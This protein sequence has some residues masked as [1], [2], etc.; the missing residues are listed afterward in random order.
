MRRARLDTRVITTLLGTELRMLLRDR[1]T[2]LFSI[3][4][5]LLVM[6][7]MMFGSHFMQQRRERSLQTLVFTYAV[8]GSE[9]A[10][11][12]ARLDTTLA[13]LTAEPQHKPE[14]ITLK[15]LPTTNPLKEL[16]DGT[17]HVVVE[18]T[19][20]EEAE[21]A[22]Q[23]QARSA[24]HRAHDV[25]ASEARDLAERPQPG[26]PALTLVYRA[27]RDTSVKAM[28]GLRKALQETR[29]LERAAAL[30]A[31]GFPIPA[32]DVATVTAKDLASAGQVAGLTLGR[33]LTLLLLMFILSGGAVVA[34]DTLAGEK[35]RGTLETLLATAAGRLE[36]VTAKLL[37]IL[38]VSLV[39][40]LIQVA[41]FLLYVAFK[42]VPTTQN[43]A[44]AVPPQVAL[45]LLAL[46]IPVAALASAALLLTS[47]Y[48]KTYKEAQLYFFPLLL[49]GMVPALA[50]FL[51]GLALRSPIVLVPVA[52]IAMAVKE[53]LTGTY[54]WP[55]IVVAL[56]VTSGTA[57]WVTFV[58]AR[59]L[60]TERLISP[61]HVDAAQA[62]GGPALF[63]RH[64]LRWFALMWAAVLIVSVNQ[65][66][67]TDIRVQ[68][69]VNLVLIFFGATMLMLK[70][71]RLEPG[72]AL[73]LRPVRPVV[74]LAVLLGA[75]TAL[76]TGV[77]VF[78]LANLVLPVPPEALRGFQ[79][80]LLPDAVP[81][82]QLLALL[83]IMPGVF[84][85][86]AFRGVLLHGL[87][88][89]LRPLP[90]ALVVGGIFGLF[91]FS[92]FRI[93]PVSF[94]GI[95]LA[96]VT[97]LTGSIFPAMLWHAVNNLMG[98]ALAHYGIELGELPVGVHLAAATILVGAFW[99]L[100]RTRTPYPGLRQ[101]H[102]PRPTGGP[103][104]QAL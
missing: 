4:L 84:E 59:A 31:H 20:A 89:R 65:K 42:L 61:T 2:I 14:S 70:K 97:L 7:V 54:D 81:F 69:I 64:V 30:Q 32:A 3:V 49:V 1:R 93:V 29:R 104:T 58:T 5:P 17:L 62:L 76:L 73:A 23:E 83:S 96:G 27:D 90:L 12:K 34:T 75:P 101:W 79:Q 92:L 91:H 102:R 15:E 40:T 86:L 45:L 77:G 63:P 99:I 82:W 68:L 35:E 6:P 94:L 85:E 57:A 16:Q 26:V 38:A 33:L 28:A 19:T 72:E 56:V 71:Y 88:R 51:P 18:A 74:W 78:R 41:N 67:G 13:R 9:A 95:M 43:F 46:F 39:I 24:H 100:W 8:T 50:P 10:A 44:A 55:M 80:E 66:E 36:I 47:G 60:A 37:A 21:Q 87:S 11:A 25:E 48:A 98:I 53:I 22:V 52:N 103:P